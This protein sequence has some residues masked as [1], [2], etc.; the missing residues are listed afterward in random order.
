[1]KSGQWQQSAGADYGAPSA[2]R[3]EERLRL[4]EVAKGDPSRGAFEQF[5]AARFSRAYGAQV[6]HFLPSLVGVRDPMARWQAASGYGEAIAGDLFLEQ[7]LDHPIEVALTAAL[8]RPVPRSRII[9]VGNLAAVSAGM[10]REFIPLLARY[11]HRRGY[12][13]VAFT[14]TRELR[15][16]F[17]RLG[18]EPLALCPADPA[19]LPDRCESWGSYYRH[20][21]QVMAGRIAHGLRVHR[22]A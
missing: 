5:I 21:P 22:E 20:D 15:N 13:W 2:R 11:L 8:G 1:M 14:A 17:R 12:Q 7:Y 18:I 6:S 3:P 9:E 10:A 19:R 4:E 16:S